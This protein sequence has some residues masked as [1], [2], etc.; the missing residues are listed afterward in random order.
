MGQSGGKDRQRAGAPGGN[1]AGDGFVKLP[2]AATAN[3]GI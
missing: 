3:E 1:G 2:P